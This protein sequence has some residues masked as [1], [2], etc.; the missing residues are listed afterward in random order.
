MGIVLE[1]RSLWTKQWFIG[2]QMSLVGVGA[3]KEMWIRG[4]HKHHGYKMWYL[5]RGIWP[6]VYPKEGVTPV[7]QAYLLFKNMKKRK[8]QGMNC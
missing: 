2:H 4:L 5:V 6:N 8:I 1:S 7:F 3:K